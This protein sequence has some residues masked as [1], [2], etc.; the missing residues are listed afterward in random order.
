M[1]RHTGEKPH[2]CTHCEKS[3]IQSTELKEH[4]YA[5]SVVLYSQGVI[6]L[7]IM[8]AHTLV[9]NH[10]NAPS[11]TRIS[12]RKVFLLAIKEHTREKQ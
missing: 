12:H 10:F 1:R 2:Q 6:I 7:N 8:L 11:V 9:L 5:A 4:I 3:F